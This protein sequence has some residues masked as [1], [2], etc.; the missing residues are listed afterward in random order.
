MLAA[1]NQSNTVWQIK[2]A[3]MNLLGCFLIGFRCFFLCAEISKVNPNRR[4]EANFSAA[5]VAG[6][7]TYLLTFF[8]GIHHLLRWG[9]L[10]QVCKSIIGFVSVNV[11]NRPR[12]PLP[13]H[14]CVCDPVS[15]IMLA[16][17]GSRKITSA[18]WLRKCRF[19]GIFLIPRRCDYIAAISARL[20]MI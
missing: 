3:V 11:V 18:V 1:S 8:C 20:E 2:L 12:W 10:S 9:R 6:N 5:L 15:G 13:C 4:A 17:D 16:V 7:A 14:N 19:S